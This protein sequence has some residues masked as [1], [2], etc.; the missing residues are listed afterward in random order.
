MA[1]QRLVFNP[2]AWQFLVVLGAWG[3]IAGR[4]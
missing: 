2:F 4:D 3:V 1:G